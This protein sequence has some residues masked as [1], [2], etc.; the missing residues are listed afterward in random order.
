MNNVVSGLKWISDIFT[1]WFNYMISEPFMGIYIV[2][3]LI[4]WIL[5]KLLNLF[6]DN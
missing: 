5:W 2:A 6:I 1:Q 4:I 3:P